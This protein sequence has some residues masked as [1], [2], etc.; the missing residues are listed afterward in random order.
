ME[1]QRDVGSYG[2]IE[3][4]DVLG[5]KY[6][7]LLYKDSRSSLYKTH[8]PLLS[9][10]AAHVKWLESGLQYSVT[11]VSVVT[12]KVVQVDL[13]STIITPDSLRQ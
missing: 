7:Q 11:N 13:T 9:R 3:Y 6:T 12:A 5:K 10:I 1:T 4:M 2:V 8:K